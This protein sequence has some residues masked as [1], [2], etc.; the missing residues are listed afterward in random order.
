[1]EEPEGDGDNHDETNPLG[2]GENMWHL[3]APAWRQELSIG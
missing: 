2:E 3:F 1:M